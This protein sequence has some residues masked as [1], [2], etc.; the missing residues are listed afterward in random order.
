MENFRVSG[1]LSQTPA[2]RIASNVEN[3][4]FFLELCGIQLG[5]MRLQPSGFTLFPVLFEVEAQRQKKQLRPHVALASR[6]ETPEPKVVFQKAK[7]TLDLDGT[8]KSEMDTFLC[9][10]IRLGDRALLFVLL[11]DTD[12]FRLVCILSLAALSPPRTAGTVLTAV[13]ADYH[14]M[15]AVLVLTLSV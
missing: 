12:L 5:K 10:D 15:L 4:Q 13:M 2:C 14:V 1:A 8:A 7:S 11:A 9:C 6:E 3:F